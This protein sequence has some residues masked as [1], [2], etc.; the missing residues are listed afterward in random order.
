MGGNSSGGA[1]GIPRTPSG[2]NL[3]VI[4][5]RGA[6]AH[7]WHDVPVGESAPDVVNCIIE[8]P[9]VRM[10]EDAPPAPCTLNPVVAARSEA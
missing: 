1:P 7:P 5:V 4:D 10:H 9:A 2:S 6:A 3:E 8:I